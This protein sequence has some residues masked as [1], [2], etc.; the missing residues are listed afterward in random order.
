M[1]V[2]YRS[3]LIAI[4]VFGIALGIVFGGGLVIGQKTAKTP[5]A[6]AAAGGAGGAASAGG[7]GAAA[8]GGGAAGG[9]GGQAAGANAVNP[10]AGQTVGAVAS[11]QGDTIT[12]RGVDGRT[13][14]VATTATTQITNSVLGS[15]NDIRPGEFVSVSPGP[16]DA[17]GRTRANTIL[18]LPPSI[19]TLLSAATPAAP[20]GQSGSG[21]RGGSTPAAGAQATATPAR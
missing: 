12:I 1:L 5:T 16:P 3:W 2:G 6:V 15:V 10:F 14:N 11:V 7:A 4:F 17:Q 18:V 19:A 9:G 20:G 21:T 13:T 8:A